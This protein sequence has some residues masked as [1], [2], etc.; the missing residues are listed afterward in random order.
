MGCSQSNQKENDEFD[1]VPSV[2]YDEDGVVMCVWGF[3]LI[4]MES[5]QQFQ[6]NNVIPQAIKQLIVNFVGKLWTEFVY[7]S[8]FDTNGICYAIGSNFG[9]KEFSNP[10]HQGLIT[11]KSSKWG[12]VNE[13]FEQILGRVEKPFGCYSDGYEN[14]WFSVNF[15]ANVKIKPTHY[16]LRHGT[17]NSHYLRMWNF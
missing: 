17:G 16:T 4:H 5:T 15:G 1:V 10:H 11:M 13:V 8:D 9:Q 6:S 3:I 7:E 14:S 12:C 2:P